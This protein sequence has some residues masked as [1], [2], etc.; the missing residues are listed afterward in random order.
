MLEASLF[1]GARLLTESFVLFKAKNYLSF[2]L[3]SE[4]LFLSGM[5]FT[6][7]I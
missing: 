7:Q 6:A 3:F 2:G 4:A 1:S 5:Q